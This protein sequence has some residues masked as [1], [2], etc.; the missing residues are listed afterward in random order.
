MSENPVVIFPE[1]EM[2][3]WDRLPRFTFLDADLKGLQQTGQE[4]IMRK[5]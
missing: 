3:A 4:Q 5:R 1:L 2:S